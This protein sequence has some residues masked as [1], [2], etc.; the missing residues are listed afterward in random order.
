[1]IRDIVER[2]RADDPVR[3]KKKGVIR[4]NASC[5]LVMGIAIKMGGVKVEGVTWLRKR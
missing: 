5:S 1:M 2:M 4:Y 3:R